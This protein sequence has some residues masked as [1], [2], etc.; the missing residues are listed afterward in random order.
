VTGRRRRW[1]RLLALALR[2]V[3]REAAL[4][5]LAEE[6]ALRTAQDGGAAAD[7]WYRGQAIRSLPAALAGRLG[8]G[9]GRHHHTDEEWT[10]TRMLED[11]VQDVRWSLR[12]LRRNPGFAAAALLTL[13]LG[14]GSATAVFTVVD[15][16][17]LQPLPYPEPDRLVRVGQN[18]PDGSNWF[19]APNYEDVRDALSSFESV[20]AWAPQG[21]NAV[22]DGE[23]EHI[24]I[25]E[26]T[27]N[28]FETLGVKPVLGRAFTLE[29]QATGAAVAVVSHDVWQRRMG[30]R[31]DAVGATLAL[32]GE[33]IEV[34]G[35]LPPVPMLPADAQVWVPIALTV[36]DWRANRGIQW[37]QVV[38]RL[39][40]EV[41]PATAA[42][43]ADRLTT[44]LREAYP[45]A[46]EQLSLTIGSLGESTVGSV[47]TE[48]R[49]LMAAVALVLLVAAINV[50]GLLL[51][52]AT[53]RRG[54]VSVRV[55]LGSGRERLAWQL[56]TESGVLALAGCLV[57]LV[58]GRLGVTA[59]LAWAPAGTPRLDEVGMH[60]S[61][62]LFAA[63]AAAL[64]AL[65]FGAAPAFQVLRAPA[66]GL[67][68]G[69]AGGRSG[70][71]LRDGLVVAQVSLALALLAGAG[72]L[73]KSFWHL[74][75][76][77]PGFEADPV[78]VAGLPVV[79]ADF[80]NGQERMDYLLG[81][82][83][84]AAALPGVTSAALGNAIP[85]VSSGPWFGY[86]LPDVE[87]EPNA[88]LLVRYRVVTPELFEALS[89]PILRGRGL[90]EDDMHPGAERVAVAS[91]EFARRHFAGSNP[92]GRPIYTGGETWTIVGIA[93]A[94]LDGVLTDPS[95]APH[96]Y[97]PLTS[98][99]RQSMTLVLRTSGDPEALVAPLR[100]LVRGISVT[101]PLT[102]LRPLESFLAN[103][104]GRRR[105]ML[106]LLAFFA[107]AALLLA[108][109]GLYG[110]LAFNVGSRTR[111]IGVRVALGAPT[112]RVRRMV[113]GHGL[114]L[115]ALGVVLG[116]LLAMWGG[117]FI[118]SLLFDVRPR[119][120]AVLA[121]VAVGLLFVAAGA[122]W[123]PARRATAVQPQ[124]ALRVE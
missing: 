21:A 52:R 17:L 20:A 6:H 26:V 9:L 16:V 98:D 110:L 27:A 106:G 116:L 109:V 57:G 77:D 49:V 97:V 68:A 100:S 11:R 84:R 29:E 83:E 118:E 102:D 31:A 7:R 117:R 92:L 53:A 61:A 37:I 23:P 4:G 43:E 32:D 95:P 85:F 47:R 54:E 99:S 66:T 19:A 64:S 39:R 33:A 72:L 93:G 38:G 101:Q 36:P 3:D 79:E 69:R 12:T 76:V 15:S 78:L 25:A 124:D 58:L 2:R 14:I 80:A 123:L 113:V 105:F 90:T 55:A 40:A 119:D 107:G 108:S 67:R 87:T 88:R 8:V 44:S 1:E 24:N 75:R 30:G 70:A 103:S 89:V 86:E 46:N 60:G 74:G 114:R 51:A 5:D 120:P 96:L 63:G 59:L 28:L 62:I 34:V 18:G 42:A 45:D 10:M 41:E 13:G 71:R 122:A 73:G 48:L 56:A 50:G 22:V 82:L 115:T 111:E 65:L 91:E 94:I 35:V 81:I 121:V 112:R 104:V